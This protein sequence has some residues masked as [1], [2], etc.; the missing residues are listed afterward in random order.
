M[1]LAAC[2]WVVEVRLAC[3]IVFDLCG[4]VYPAGADA[5]YQLGSFYLCV[6]SVAS[7]IK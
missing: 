2:G 5:P 7:P 3:A 1:Y 6:E 4:D